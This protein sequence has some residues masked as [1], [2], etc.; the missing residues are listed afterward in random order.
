MVNKP[1]HGGV[2]IPFGLGFESCYFLMSVVMNREVIEQHAPPG[3]DV[4][5]WISKYCEPEL[6]RQYPANI[7]KS[8]VES[9]DSG[10]YF[11]DPIITG[12]H[13]RSVLQV[14]RD[15]MSRRY[16]NLLRVA[17]V[18]RP[19]RGAAGTRPRGRRRRTARHRRDARLLASPEV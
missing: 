17:R 3:F 7:T 6:F 16:L 10:G 13:R 19:S 5:D 12:G 11:T 14:A 18:G 4:K 9:A 15:V 1:Q 2:N 8:M